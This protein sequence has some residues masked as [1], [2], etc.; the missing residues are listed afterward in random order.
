MY[1]NIIDKFQ[2]K[3]VKKTPLRQETEFGKKSNEGL[4]GPPEKVGL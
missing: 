2:D 1:E 4:E 3:E